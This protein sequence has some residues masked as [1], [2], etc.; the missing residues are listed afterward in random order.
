MNAK[1]YLQRIQKIDTIIKNKVVEKALY[2][3]M[4]YERATSTTAST[5]GE[6]VKSSGSQQ[7]MADCIYNSIDYERRV[8]R[9]IAELTAEKE[10]IIATIEQ[11]PEDKYDL[12]HLC[13]VQGKTLK[14]VAA[15]RNE[16]YSL[17]TTNHGIA[18]TMV[19]AILEE[20]KATICN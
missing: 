4:M 10:E 6:R 14:Q 7:K 3:A 19:D 2:M 13:Y 18:L 17:V 15:I 20:R 8:D 9:R 11:L 12:L 1:K 16:S 5:E